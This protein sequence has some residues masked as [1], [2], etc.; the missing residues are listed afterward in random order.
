M[1][2]HI[3]GSGIAG[4][5]AAVYLIQ[6]AKVDGRDI[7]IYDAEKDVGGAMAAG[8]QSP[9]GSPATGYVRPAARIL[10]REY[11]CTR[12]LL[13]RFYP[14]QNPTRT[15]EDEI[16]E[17]NDSRPYHDTT[18]LLKSS[19]EVVSSR[20]FGVSFRDRVNMLKLLLTPEHRLE[21]KAASEFFTPKFF[22]S[23]FWLNWSTIM[24]PLPQ[25]SAVELKRYFLRFLHVLPELASMAS[26]WRM[27]LNQYDAVV[28]PIHDWLKRN[29]VEFRTKALV[30]DMGFDPS[31]ANVTGF[32]IRD[33]ETNQVVKHVAVGLHDRVLVT[34]GSQL[35]DM[36][37]G[38]QEEAPRAPTSPGRSWSLWRKIATGHAKF[39]NPDAFFGPDASLGAKW[40]TFT[41]TTR[42]PT[43][44]RDLAGLTGIDPGRAGLISL[45]DSPWLITVVAFHQP[46]FLK[47]PEDVM[48]WWGFG[49]YPDK[50]GRFVQKRMSECSGAEILTETILQ[51]GLGEERHHII[52]VSNCI[53]CLLPYAGNVWAVRKESDRPKVIPDGAKNFAFIGQFCEIPKDTMFT[54]EYSV[55]SASQAVSGLFKL[56]DTTPPVYEGWKDLR[57]VGAAIK[58]FLL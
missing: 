14:I 3:V 55:R 1:T 7:T 40:V 19:G 46:H 6:D 26:V 25:H 48:V 16:V 33:T 29:K 35:A 24:G 58:T 31:H 12:E 2:V 21:G 34:L 8:S 45:V 41:V 11:R 22:H 51:L 4:L 50:L 44:F 37:I 38:T 28:A 20:H 9:Y 57:A 13:D 56:P 17:F 52:D 23:E 47:Q 27:P 18:R 39:G 53:P 54:M 36:S 42:D 5:A 49:L 30:E 43:L 10:D 32:D 15:I